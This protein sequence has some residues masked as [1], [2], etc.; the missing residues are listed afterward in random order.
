MSLRRRGATAGALLAL[1]GVPGDARADL[2]KR[3]GSKLAAGALEKVQPAMAATIADVD[4]RVTRHEDR[5]ADIASGVVRKVDAVAEQR[6]NQVDH[7][8]EARLLQATVEASDL[9]DRAF[10]RVDGVVG[11]VDLI[12]ARRVA[13]LDQLTKATLAAANQAIED[14]IADVGREVHGALDRTDEIIAARIDQVDELAG[15]RLGNLDVIA[16]KQRIAL[17]Q[18]AVRVAVLV[19]LVAFVVFVLRRLWGTYQELTKDE[20]DAEPAPDP[21]R[22]RARRRARAWA[23]VKGLG[24]PFLGHVAVAAAAAGL[25][26][27]LYDR[28]PLGAKTEAAELAGFHER[29]LDDSLRRFEFTRARFHASQLEYLTPERA[30]HY[31]ALAAKGELLRDL[32]ARPTLWAT[33]AGIAEL[34]ERLKGVRRLLDRAPDP[35]V[36]TVEGLL[37]W[38]TG[39]SRRHEH[40]AVSLFARALRLR[41]QGFA[42]AP[43]ARAY[44]ETFVRA[45]YAAEAAG[46]GRDA[47]TQEGL[48]ALLAGAPPD[49]DHPL[50]TN[51]KLLRLMQTV[52]ADSSAAYLAMAKAHA[53]LAALARKGGAAD[54]IEA[55]R[56]ERTAHA[57]QVVKAFEDFDAKLAEAPELGGNPAVL[58]VFRLD[59]ALFSRAQWFLK[60]DRADD[61]APLLAPDDE[62]PPAK[63]GGPAKAAKPPKAGEKPASG[64]PDLQVRMELAPP[65]VVWARRYRSL[66]E[67]PARE[68]LELQEAE[69]FKV[70]ERGARAFE[71]ALIEAQLDPQ[72]KNQANVAR[73]AARLGFY[74]GGDGDRRPDAHD[75]APGADD[76]ALTE[77]LL[78]RGVRLLLS[79]RRVPWR[80]RRPRTRKGCCETPG[81]PPVR[82]LVIRSV[83]RPSRYRA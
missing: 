34:S 72:E 19:G 15:R 6:L 5:I 78:S 80:A 3:L 30:A 39:A 56:R 7:I 29:E 13:E 26:F 57:A 50:A 23:F 59:D 62:A 44:V 42:L 54:E 63:A 1:L 28:L 4:R 77:A 21:K 36:L 81:K 45:P 32:F 61:V 12:T 14:R 67:G 16:S 40:E 31:R 17:E 69:R 47:E 41:P 24:A 33:D 60:H 48:R 83:L 65:R 35:D 10:A 64:P 18:T 27:V 22:R 75:L 55:K 74:V 46:H 52:D 66:I 43:L 9:A 71:L 79:R 51:L 73:S 53:E 38:Q 49:D 25:L 37:K 70:R 11:R 2:V 20:P 58:G 8:L 82:F 68:L 76:K